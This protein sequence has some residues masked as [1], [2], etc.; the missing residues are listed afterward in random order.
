MARED[1]SG[2]K[3]L[4]A[5]VV[6]SSNGAQTVK[7]LRS[8]VSEKLPE[9][10]VPSAFVFLDSLPLTANGKVDRKALPAPDHD[11]P[12]LHGSYVAPGNLVE[13]QLVGIWAKVLK[14]LMAESYWRP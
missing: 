10:M 5:Y 2:D 14:D 4:V 6:S 1:S 12:E 11:R 13:E 9:Y 7:E 8:F 3:R